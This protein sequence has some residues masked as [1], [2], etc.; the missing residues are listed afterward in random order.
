MSDMRYWRQSKG[1]NGRGRPAMP[2][3]L[4]LHIID[5]VTG[6]VVDKCGWC[7]NKSDH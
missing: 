4:L 3:G 7:D 6:A 2:P 1:R 5:S